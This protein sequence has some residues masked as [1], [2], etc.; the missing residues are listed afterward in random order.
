MKSNNNNCSCATPLTP[1]ANTAFIK[2]KS[3]NKNDIAE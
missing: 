3:H 1:T 2:R